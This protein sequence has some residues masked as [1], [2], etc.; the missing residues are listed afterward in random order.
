MIPSRRGPHWISYARCGFGSRIVSSGERR[1][2][3][4]EKR[5]RRKWDKV[6]MEMEM[7]AYRKERFQPRVTCAYVKSCDQKKKGRTEGRH[8][9]CVSV[10]VVGVSVI[11]MRGS[12]GT[13]R[14]AAVQYR[15]VQYSTAYSS[16]SIPIVQAADPAG[17]VVPVGQS[18]QYADPRVSAYV[19]AAQ[20]VH[21]AAPCVGLYPV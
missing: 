15:T 20:G 7:K 11:V 4:E 16:E 6:R 8:T 14:H 1:T 13:T 5:K 19:P 10:G 3:Q 2:G 12:V 17:D 18:R 21:D 9:R